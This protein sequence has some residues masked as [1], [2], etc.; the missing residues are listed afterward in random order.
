MDRLISVKGHQEKNNLS[1][2]ENF[3]VKNASLYASTIQKGIWKEGERAGRVI[4]KIL[5]EK[6]LGREL[7]DVPCGMGRLAIPLAKLG[8]NVTG[9]DISPSYVAIARQK[10]ARAHVQERA[11]FIVG[12]VENMSE[13]LA[14]KNGFFDA[15]INIHT[16]LGYGEMRDDLAFLSATRKVVKRDGIFIMTARRN[17]QNIHRHLEGNSFR[18]TN[19]TL[20]LQSNRYSKKNSRLFTTWRFYTG[21]ADSRDETW[22]RVGKFHT[23]VRLYSTEELINLLKKTGWKVLEIGESLLNRNKSLSEESQG[24]YILAMTV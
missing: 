6:Q 7:L 13:L 19:R 14:G 8:V 17:K 20:L 4:F 24:I 22:K 23:N 12:R 5:K 9:L 11:N 15:A 10:A 16:N 2:V 21:G 3:Y 1:W 18:E